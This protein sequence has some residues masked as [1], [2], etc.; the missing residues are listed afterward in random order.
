MKVGNVLFAGIAKKQPQSVMAKSRY[1][2][3]DGDFYLTL[4]GNND[5]DVVSFHNDEVGE[6]TF[7]LGTQVFATFNATSKKVTVSDTTSTG[8]V[9][10]GYVVKELITDGDYKEVWV[11]I[12]N[13]GSGFTALAVIPHFLTYSLPVGVDGTD[14]NGVINKTAG[15]I[16]VEAVK[17]TDVTNLAATFTVTDSATVEVGDTSQES[18]E[19]T[20]NFSDSV[21]YTLT[22][23]GETKTYTV[24]V[25]VEQA[26]IPHFLTY[27]LP[28]GAD[29]ADVD[30][31]INT[32]DGT[33]T[34]EAVKGTDVSSLKA[35]FTVTDSATVK[36]G[37]TAQTSDTTTNNFSN[38]VVYTLTLDGETKTYTVTVNVADE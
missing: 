2:K 17:G 6:G 14:V 13:Q 32:T 23:D 20:N 16:T 34:V 24:T 21:V 18:G 33:I 38:P 4:Y 27:S 36:V 3:V 11:E 29:G 22:L 37:N 30:G 1:D 25:N 28:V 35:T 10:I 31:V 7:S 9:F 19:T 12:V 8:A 26:V 5:G 15:T